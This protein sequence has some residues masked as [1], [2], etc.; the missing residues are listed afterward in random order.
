MEDKTCYIMIQLMIEI[1]FFNR[2]QSGLLYPLHI[3]LRASIQITENGIR[4]FCS[5]Q[6]MIN[7]TFYYQRILLNKLRNFLIL[8]K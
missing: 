7:F 8:L 6:Y 1:V 5:H 2:L 4:G 3:E